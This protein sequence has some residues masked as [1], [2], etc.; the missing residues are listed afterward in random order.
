MP[1]IFPPDG[2]P[3][4]HGEW[5]FGR[6]V[7]TDAHTILVADLWD[8]PGGVVYLYEASG[9][10]CNR[11]HLC[12]SADIANG[13]SPDDNANGIPDECETIPGDVTGDG[14][15]NADDLVAVI[16]AWGPCPAPPAVCPADIAPAPDGD[17]E[18]NA[19]DLIMVILNWG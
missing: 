3:H 4:Y 9:A 10:D 19:D 5:G 2:A 11:N 13:T 18:V 6:R 1:A 15:V 14:Q 8:P 12:D 7:A 16:L 17:G